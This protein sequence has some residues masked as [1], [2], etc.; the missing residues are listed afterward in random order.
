MADAPRRG[1]PG[2]FTL[3]VNGKEIG[4]VK[5]PRTPQA[6]WS[7]SDTFDVGVDLGSPVGDYP[8]GWRFKG[9]LEKVTVE[10]K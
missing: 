4:T 10:L 7:L 8:A 1:K 5:A 3:T 9:T 6:G 2:T